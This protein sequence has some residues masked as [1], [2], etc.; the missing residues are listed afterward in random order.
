MW[1][2][3]EAWSS[4]IREE[5]EDVVIFGGLEDTSAANIMDC[6]LVA[7]EYMEEDLRLD[8]KS[9]VI[10]NYPVIDINPWICI[11]GLVEDFASERVLDIMGDIIVSKGDDLV[12]GETILLK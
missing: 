2:G 3:D 4:M 11:S 5:D 12:L 7:L 6:R 10:D 1:K 8:C 9:F